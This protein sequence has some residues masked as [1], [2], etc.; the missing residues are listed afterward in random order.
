MRFIRFFQGGR[1]DRNEIVKRS[2]FEVFGEQPGL[3]ADEYRIT[4]HSPSGR[5]VLSY[6]AN[7][8]DVSLSF[9][10]VGAVTAF[11]MDNE[12]SV[13][14]DLVEMRDARGL[15]GWSLQDPTSELPATGRAAYCWAAREAA[16]KATALD[17]PFRPDS[18]V[19]SVLNSHSFMWT[20][21]EDEQRVSG[22]GVFS[23]HGSMIC[24]LAVRN[25]VW[26]EVRR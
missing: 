9:S 24:A 6:G 14:I 1:N 18:F 19:F 5:P 11:V 3:S 20:F 22:E 7:V 8:C 26:R 15:R 16:Y 10:H 17:R 12:A 21:S 4:Y 23:L 25:S 2:V 13:G